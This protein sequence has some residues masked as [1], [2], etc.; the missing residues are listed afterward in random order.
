M[1]QAQNEKNQKNKCG[2]GY[3][4]QIAESLTAENGVMGNYGRGPGLGPKTGG[5][6]AGDQSAEE[7]RKGGID[8]DLIS[9]WD[10][11]GEAVHSV[12]WLSLM[13]RKQEVGA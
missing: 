12:I 1:N 9:I 2:N 13:E 7:D 8:Q 5:D 3:P 6:A 11:P 4:R 10:D